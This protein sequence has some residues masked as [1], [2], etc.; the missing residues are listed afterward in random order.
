MR[1]PKWTGFTPSAVAT[2]SRMGARI[3]QLEMLSMNMPTISRNTFIM[4]STTILLLLRPRMKAESVSGTCSSVITY[5]KLVD[6]PTIKDVA[7][8]MMTVSFMQST[9]SFQRISL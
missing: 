9:N 3:V 8:A 7:P 5:A 6:M 2:G 4:S 1:M